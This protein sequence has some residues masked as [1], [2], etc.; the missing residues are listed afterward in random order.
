MKIPL[1][2]EGLLYMQTTD[3]E[4]TDN[5]QT[6]THSKAL[7]KAIFTPRIPSMLYT[8][9]SRLDIKFVP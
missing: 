3:K 7:N 4:A 2:N 5:Y 6:L 8:S 1:M 9:L